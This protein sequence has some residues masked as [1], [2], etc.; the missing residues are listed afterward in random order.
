MKREDGSWEVF[1]DYVLDCAAA[2][3]CSLASFSSFEVKGLSPDAATRENARA[4]G[5]T[6]VELVSHRKSY[7]ILTDSRTAVIFMFHDQLWEESLLPAALLTSAWYIGAMGSKATHAQ[8]C[9]KLREMGF[10][11]EQISRVRG[12]ASV[13]SG[14]EPAPDIAISI[15]ADIVR[16]ERGVHARERTNVNLNAAFAPKDEANDRELLSMGTPRMAAPE[17][18]EEASPTVIRERFHG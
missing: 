14:A 6:A 11:S 3:L 9:R 10:S 13:F 15:L 5:A 7:E 1:E 4:L 12:P 16:D 8:R 17:E 2:R 18:K